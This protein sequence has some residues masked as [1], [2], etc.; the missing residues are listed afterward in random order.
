MSDPANIDAM[1]H[2][3]QALRAPLALQKLDVDYVNKTA[4]L[5][6]VDEFTGARCPA[7]VGLTGFTRLWKPK[8]A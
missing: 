7:A 5:F 2:V 8:R 3:Y 4:K 6:I 1:H